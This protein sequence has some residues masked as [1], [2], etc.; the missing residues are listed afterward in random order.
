MPEIDYL[1]DDFFRKD[2]TLHIRL[3]PQRSPFAKWGTQFARFWAAWE[4][5][6]FC[7]ADLCQ[8]AI[9]MPNFDL[10]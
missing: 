1:P 4:C 7:A 10:E 8:L 5:Q 6:V 2:L 9:G 3:A